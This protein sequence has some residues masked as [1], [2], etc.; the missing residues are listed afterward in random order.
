MCSDWMQLLCVRCA[1]SLMAKWA[2]S[3]IYRS[4]RWYVLVA[5]YRSRIR[6]GYGFLYCYLSASFNFTSHLTASRTSCN[7]FLASL[8]HKSMFL[9]L[10]RNPT[11]FLQIWQIK[12]ASAVGVLAGERFYMRPSLV[13][14]LFYLVCLGV[15]FYFALVSVK[16]VL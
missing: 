12:P 14:A 8:R 9:T 2:T 3:G 5:C 13:E 15:L 11:G 6:Y 10:A 1:F 7:L 16:G 4:S